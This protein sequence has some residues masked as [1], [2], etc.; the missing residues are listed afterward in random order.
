MQGDAVNNVLSESRP[1]CNV[2]GS[3]VW[4][5]Q[6][7]KFFIDLFLQLACGLWTKASDTRVDQGFLQNQLAN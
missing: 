2:D 4:Y 3:I 1:S 6:Q 5:V 7:L